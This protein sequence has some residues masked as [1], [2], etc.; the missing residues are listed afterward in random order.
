MTQRR[1]IGNVRIKIDP[2][3]RSGE[4]QGDG[5]PE[6]RR[7]GGEQ[8]QRRVRHHLHRRTQEQVPIPPK[9]T[10]TGL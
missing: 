1:P 10:N 4:D 2:R 3:C 7:A 8:G 9:V 6:A 5:R